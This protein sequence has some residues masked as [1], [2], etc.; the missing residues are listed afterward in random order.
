MEILVKAS[1]NFKE[2]CA[3]IKIHRTSGGCKERNLSIY[4][5]RFESY[6]SVS[7]IE[8]GKHTPRTNPEYICNSP[9][10]RTALLTSSYSLKYRAGS[11]RNETQHRT[12]LPP[13]GRSKPARNLNGTQIFP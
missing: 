1:L 5:L 7:F 8:V 4:E 9:T 11:H 13:P 3:S 12:P 6:S 2:L 10:T